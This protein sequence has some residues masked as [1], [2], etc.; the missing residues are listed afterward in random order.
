[1]KQSWK[2]GF[3]VLTV[4]ELAY[5]PVYYY[6]K[7]LTVYILSG[8]YVSCCYAG[9]TLEHPCVRLGEQWPRST[10]PLCL[11]H[12]SQ[13]A[14]SSQLFLWVQLNLSSFCEYNN[15]KLFLQINLNYFCAYKVI[16][17]LYVRTTQS[18]QLLWVQLNISCFLLVQ[19]DV[20][21]VC[22]YNSL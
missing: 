7:L 15:I 19:F 16:L 18:Q 13:A 12:S 14:R 10:R 2:T 21:S 17:T 5:L 6:S 11:H 1:M 22:E 3:I 4:R 9:L 8:R 20:N